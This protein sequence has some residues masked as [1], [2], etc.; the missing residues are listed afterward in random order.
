MVNVIVRRAL[1]ANMRM[2]PEETGL[3]DIRLVLPAVGEVTG[4]GI[5]S[6]NHN[7]NFKMRAAVHSSGLVSALA[8]ATI[9]FS[10]GGTASEPQF[11]PDVGQLASEELKERLKGVK[12]GGVD[13]GKSADLLL[14]PDRGH[15]IVDPPSRLVLFDRM[16]EFFLKNL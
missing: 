15:S 12:V 9:A 13:A 5:I 6:P 4:D 16:T 2:A 11:R 14:F 1:S 8:P 10:V 3:Q 7:L